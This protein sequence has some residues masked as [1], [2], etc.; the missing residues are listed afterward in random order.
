MLEGNQEWRRS[1]DVTGGRRGALGH[2]GSSN[3]VN[4]TDGNRVEP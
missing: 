2:M 3:V 1:G 4:N